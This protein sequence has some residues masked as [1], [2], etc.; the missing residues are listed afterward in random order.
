MGAQ[1][2]LVLGLARDVML[3]GHALGVHPHVHVAG[4][5]PQAVVD[6]AVDQLGVAQP[7]PGPRA[8]EQVRPQVHV[9]HAP[10]HD[11]VRVPGPD[12]SGAQHHGLHAGAAYLIDG[13]GADALR[14]PALER[15]LA[16][17][18]LA[19]TGL[20]D[21]PH[22]R[23]VDL[24]GGDAGALDCGAD[25]RG[26]Q[27]GGR[28]GGKAAAELADRRPGGGQD[29]DV[30]HAL[31]VPRCG[32]WPLRSLIRLPG[33]DQQIDM[34]SGLEASLWL[35]GAHRE[36]HDEARVLERDLVVRAQRGDREAFAELAFR[37][38]DRLLTTA[39]RILPEVY[40]AED[41]T[42][43]D[44]RGCVAR[45]AEAARPRQVRQG[46][47]FRILQNACRAELRRERRW[48]PTEMRRLPIEDVAGDA[49]GRAW[50]IATSWNER[51]G[52]SLFEHRIVL[53]MQH[54]LGLTL[55]QIAE[56]LEIPLGTARSRS[57]YAKRA[58]RAAL[59]ADARPSEGVRTA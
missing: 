26:A 37:M 45:A 32:V 17:R 20:D 36:G 43:A 16:R 41:A 8:R 18:R 13:G 15:R 35:T 23:L 3:L 4:R 50:P 10:G 46:W 21:L 55:E 44:D 59:E 30:A 14:Q 56:K 29:E 51:S 34:R 22:D 6:G 9:L 42:L 57:H 5:A 31:M 39:Q 40:Q 2:E 47:S 7:I 27:V 1:R 19:R 25:G 24:L 52:G 11:H 54:Y 33:H 28:N 12:R 49:G 38:G 48:S 53:V 58:M